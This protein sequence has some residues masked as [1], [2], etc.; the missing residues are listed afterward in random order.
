MPK[1]NEK[2]PVFVIQAV[3]QC[4]DEEIKHLAHVSPTL[5]DAIYFIQKNKD[6]I[7]TRDTWFW[8]VTEMQVG[9]QNHDGYHPWLYDVDGL[10]MK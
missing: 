4:G 1:T 8:A 2:S 9:V 7:V 6:Y 5:D 3:H 10:E